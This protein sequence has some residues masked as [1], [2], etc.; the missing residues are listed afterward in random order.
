MK[1]DDDL[2]KKILF[3]SLRAMKALGFIVWH[4]MNG[5]AYRAGII[6]LSDM[7]L[8]F[9]GTIH[10]IAD[11]EHLRY[12]AKEKINDDV[13]AKAGKLFLGFVFNALNFVRVSAVCLLDNRLAI[14][15]IKK[16]GFKEE[17]IRRNSVIYNGKARNALTFGIIKDDI[18]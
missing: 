14:N 6:Y 15:F 12:S 17:G 18:K 9:D 16:I 13:M 5:K 3:D 8:G 4:Y 2:L 7:E 1:Q 11:Y 10:Y